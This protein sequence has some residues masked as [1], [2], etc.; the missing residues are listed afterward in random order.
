M[1]WKESLARWSK[2]MSVLSF[3]HTILLR[4]CFWIIYFVNSHHF[5]FVLK[6]WAQAMWHVARQPST[7][8]MG[9]CHVKYWVWN[10][11][12]IKLRFK[13]RN[14]KPGSSELPYLYCFG[15]MPVLPVW[16]A[17]SF[18]FRPLRQALASLFGEG[19]LSSDNFHI[20]L[21]VICVCI[22]AYNIWL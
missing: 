5:Q 22:S 10:R 15:V 12:N 17:Q 4:M 9:S 13:F 1:L 19:R 21:S 11:G 18:Y 6:S 7:I 14:W 16:L 2:T 8:R 3:C 20:F